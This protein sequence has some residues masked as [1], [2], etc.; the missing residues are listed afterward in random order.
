MDYTG[1]LKRAWNVTWRYKIL[2]LLGLFAGGAGSGGF[3]WN[4]SSYRGGTSTSAPFN[5]SSWASFQSAVERYL[6]LIIIAFVVLLIIGVV[7][8]VVSIA[9]RGALIHLV[10]E[11]EEQREVR[12][13]AGWRVGFKK[14]WRI[15]G[16]E[17]LAGL[18]ILVLVVLIGA[19]A[20]VAIAAAI[21]RGGSSA[22]AAGQALAGMAIGGVCLL[23]VF[24]VIAIALGIIL[25]IVAQLA[26]R[27]AVLQDR[28]AIDSLKQGWSDLWSRR[29]AGLMFLIQVGVAIAYGIVFGIVAVVLM[30]PG[31]AL[32][33]GGALPVGGVLI[34]LAGLVLLFPAAI[35]ASFYSAAWTIFFRRMTGME[36]VQVATVPAYQPPYPPAPPAPYTSPAYPTVPPEMPLEPA[37]APPAAPEM[38]APPMPPVPPAPSDG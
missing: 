1:I 21:S 10:N 32:I 27:Y 34:A 20:G 11:A 24:A 36:Q 5:S 37:P 28:H 9:A 31:I 3:N 38:P 33:I 22:Q 26:L 23:L 17:F 14:W 16:V 12:A 7:W 15:F 18:P 4:T 30:L 6:P 13:A 35:F 8:W 25:G 29:G 2:W 19:V